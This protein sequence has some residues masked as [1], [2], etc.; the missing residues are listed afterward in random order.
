MESKLEA[1]MILKSNKLTSEFEDCDC[2]W[3]DMYLSK[4]LQYYIQL[5]FSK[6]DLDLWGGS[7][8]QPI[9][10]AIIYFYPKPNLYFGFGQ[11]KLPGNRERVV[12]SGNLQFADRSI[13]N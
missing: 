6:S 7:Y 1:E 4:K 13:A 10:D 8:A 2:D 3:K 11:S 9:R 12:S 5:G